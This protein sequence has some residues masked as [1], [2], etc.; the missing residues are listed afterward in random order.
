MEFKDRLK[1]VRQEKQLS[2]QALANA[3]YV[4]RSAVAKWENGLGLPNESSYQ[5]L[6]NYLGMTKE[7]FPLN[8]EVE[9]IYVAK[10]EKI[11]T[12]S[13]AVFVL[14]FLLTLGVILHIA[15]VG[16]NGYGFTATMAAGEVWKDA[17]T[18]Q[19]PEYIFYYN[20]VSGTIIDH[21]CA[22]EKKFVGYQKIEIEKRSKK[23]YGENGKLVGCLYSFTGDQGYYHFFI[24]A[25]HVNDETPAWG[26]EMYLLSEV[27]MGN[28]TIPVLHNSYFKTDTEINELFYSNGHLY[29]SP[30]SS[31]TSLASL[32]LF[33]PAL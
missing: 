31:G 29:G 25:K 2:Q 3:I 1:K 22:V 19:T 11:F 33:E 6:L 8:E 9:V 13:T 26:V 16:M 27:N 14:S 7:E 10:N 20:T 15:S 4:S 21:F 28:E 23:V 30:P 12:L 18:I 17:E 5:S 24:S 32:S